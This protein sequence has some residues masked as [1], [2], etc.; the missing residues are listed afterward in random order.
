MQYSAFTSK[1]VKQEKS[2]FYYE[3]K[4]KEADKDK[5]SAINNLKEKKWHFSDPQGINEEPQ[6]MLISEKHGK[7]T[8][9]NEISGIIIEI[10]TNKNPE[11]KKLFGI[12]QTLQSNL[13]LSIPREIEFSISDNGKKL[14]G[15][16]S[17]FCSAKVW[18]FCVSNKG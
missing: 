16:P 1:L 5:M 2:Q 9:E 11:S 4:S 14:R 12:Y 6:P 18:E 8:L 10:D 7:Y 15:Y 17:G 13:E 3:N